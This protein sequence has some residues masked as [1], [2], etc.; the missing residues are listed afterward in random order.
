MDAT[1]RR[2]VDYTVGF[3]RADLT[4]AVLSAA[5]HHVVDTV[6]VAVAGHDSEQAGIGA[7]MARTAR[8][9]S[10]AEPATVIGHGISTTPDLAAFANTIMV[11]TYD[12]NDGMQAKGG[13]HPSDMLPGI[14]AVG[15]VSHATGADVLVAITLAYE[16]L[17]G[18][19]RNV[20]IGDLGYDQGT[21]M[22]PATAL[23]CGKLLGLRPDQLAHAASL[24]LVPN[25]PLGVSRWGALSMMKGCA[26]AFAVRNA[27]FAVL[28]AQAG[29]TGPDEPFDGIYGL[30][31][32]TGP[33]DVDLP[34][35]AGGPSVIEMSHQKPVPA[36]T[37]VLA[38]LELVPDIRAFNPVD[39]ITSITIDLP[40]HAFEH[41]A[42][43]PK[44][45][46]RTRETA[47][48]SLPYMLAV[49]LLDGELTLDSYREE[50]FTDPRVR[51]LMG[52]IVC[53][54]DEELSR[55]RRELMAGVTRP[56]PARIDV[57][58]ADGRQYR[59]EVLYYRGHH[60]NP[61]SRAEIDDKFA[62]ICDRC[63]PAG[64]GARLRAA[65]WGIERCPDIAQLMA[66]LATIDKDPDHAA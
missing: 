48:H 42:D 40:D 11:R 28:L 29:L 38:L 20:P 5:L 56:A 18:L 41:I 55:L 3:S 61:M 12:W 17:G 36:E 19:G 57:R 16:L 45:D 65:W 33:F 6:A 7:R 32:K 49:A 4:P 1:T 23:A 9:A 10:G 59:Q 27:V 2:I 15:E 51:A 24:A 63:M 14:L 54:P 22:A 26:T 44:Y 58:W 13:G 39:R 64:A 62:S 8:P 60:R 53:R 47:D 35:L 34:V 21:L 50:R 43:P 31:H 66:A 37:Q 46:P 25:V 30:R 52:R